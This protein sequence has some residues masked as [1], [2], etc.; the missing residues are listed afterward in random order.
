VVSTLIAAL[1]GCVMLLA[2]GFGDGPG[3]SIVGLVVLTPVFI[4]SVAAAA[5][6]PIEV[7]VATIRAPGCSVAAGT[8]SHI[9]GSPLS[10]IPIVPIAVPDAAPGVVVVGG[11]SAGILAIPPVVGRM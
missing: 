10:P 4:T 3:R 11:L 1:L 8:V 2:R 6:V 5:V 7:I 9:A